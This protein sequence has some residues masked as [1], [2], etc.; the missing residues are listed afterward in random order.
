MVSTVYTAN[1]N[2]I[3]SEV[4][5]KMLE[6]NVGCLP[7]ID[8]EDKLVGFLSETDFAGKE[9]L[10]PFSR[11][12]APQLFGKWLNEGGIEEMYNNAKTIKVKEIMTTPPITIEEDETITVLIEKIMKYNIHRIPVVNNDKLVGIVS[13]RDL[14]KLL[15]SK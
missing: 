2:D 11:N 9:K 15:L 5:V 3:L 1:E 8:D 4:A 14:L 7:V 6:K 12:H 13:R 10:I